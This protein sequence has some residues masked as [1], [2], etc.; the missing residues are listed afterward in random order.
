MSGSLQDRVR[1]VK[2]TADRSPAF[3]ARLR[4]LEGFILERFQLA[5]YDRIDTPILEFVDLHERKSG[6]GI[7]EKLFEI[8]GQSTGR[9]CLRP[10]LTAGIVRAYTEVEP[11]PALPWRV[12]HAGP[13]F[14]RESSG[15]T[16]RLRQFH[17]VGVERLGD[18]GPLADAEIIWLAET[19]LSSLG[20]GDATIRVGHVGLT[21][22][23]LG[24]SGLP[25]TAQAALVEMLSEAA[26]EGGDVGS[27]GRGL[28]HFTEWLRQGVNAEVEDLPL[29]IKGDDDVGVDRLFRTLVPV[30][31]GRRSGHEIISRL[32]RKWELGHSWFSKLEAV[33]SQ[34]AV[35]VDLRGPISD[36]LDRLTSEFASLAPDS[37]ASL[38][39]LA[40]SLEALGV[41][42][43]RVELDLGFG[44]GIGFYSQMIFELIVPTPEGPVEVCGGGR[45]DGLARVL[46]SDRDD[47]GAGFAFGLER[48]DAVLVSRG[49]QFQPHRPTTYE[50]IPLQPF[51]LGQAAEAAALIRARGFR[52]ILQNQ[53][54]RAD[55]AGKAAGGAGA[56]RILTMSV[57]GGESQLIRISPDGKS[58]SLKVFGLSHLS[59]LLDEETAS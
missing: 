50:V 20:I 16:D 12:S 23:I 28:D 25:A 53:R 52:A 8:S 58:T 47:R 59:A 51:A 48:L 45:Y 5:G 29:P 34:I 44:R 56:T 55:Q 18:A 54:T 6:A 40:A 17:Q 19:S 27:I 35:L 30:V 7:V 36:I 11:T 21:L 42:L 15:R 26:A 49:F 24:R 57:K 31:N 37:I 46:G 41:P 9:V 14:R 22:E 13:A 1:L 10:E 38:Q 4:T 32:R 43:D 3:D 2:G 39:T 33:R